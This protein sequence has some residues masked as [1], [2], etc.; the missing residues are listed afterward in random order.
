MRAPDRRRR[1]SPV[2]RDLLAD[3]RRE[4]RVEGEDELLEVARARSSSRMKTRRVQEVEDGGDAAVVQE[5]EA[6]HLVALMLAAR[7]R[8]VDERHVGHAEHADLLVGVPQVRD[9]E[10]LRSRSRRSS[11][12]SVPKK[13]CAG[14]SAWQP[15]QVGDARRCPAR[16]KKR[17]RPSACGGG[18]RVVEA[19]GP[20]SAAARPRAMKSVNAVMS[21]AASWPSS[22]PSSAV[23][24]DVERLEGELL[25]ERRA[26]RRRTCAPVRS[27]R[28]C[29][30]PW[31]ARPRRVC[32]VIGPFI[33]WNGWPT[34]DRARAGWGSASTT[35]SGLPRSQAEAV[36]VAEDVAA[37]A[38]RLAV[39]RGEAR[40]VEE[41]AGPST[42]SRRLGIVQRV[43]R[44]LGA[45]SSVS[46]TFTALSKRVST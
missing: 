41:A 2:E 26:D 27:P 24:G 37:R 16:L 10:L 28:Q 30:G 15:L 5:A 43:L 32:V 17:S 23:E 45:A 1:S 42:T 33:G 40:V 12:P 6:A 8:D 25:V 38:R 46:I 14:S 34:A 29:I 18:Q 7:G 9:L 13:P 22:R 20:G 11:R 44:D 39:A 4:G 21:A 36:E 19:R 35:S 3:D 31:F